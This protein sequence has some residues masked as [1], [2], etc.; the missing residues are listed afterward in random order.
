VTIAHRFRDGIHDSQVAAEIRES[1]AQIDRPVLCGQ[2]AHQREDR[3][4]DVG[5]PRWK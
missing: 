2:R 3:R 1:L 4:A 5:Q